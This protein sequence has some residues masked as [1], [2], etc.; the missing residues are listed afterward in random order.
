MQPRIIY[1]RVHT[2]V[3]QGMAFTPRYTTYYTP[4]VTTVRK[5][6][7]KRKSVRSFTGV[8]GKVIKGFLVSISAANKT[9]KIKSAKGLTYTIPIQNFCSADVQYMKSWWA[10]R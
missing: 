10:N 6:V 8:N 5:Q 4:R 1:Q 2:P 7:S 9:A 3:A